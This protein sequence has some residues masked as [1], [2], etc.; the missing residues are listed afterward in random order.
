MGKTKVIM[1][2]SIIMNII[3]VAGNA[4]GVFAL[5]AGVAGVA[6]PSLISRIFAANGRS[7]RLYNLTLIFR[8]CLCKD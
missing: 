4:I 2:V 7:L 1:E 6:Y 8:E 5:H 3:N